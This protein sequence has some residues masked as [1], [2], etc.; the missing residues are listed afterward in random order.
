MSEKTYLILE[1]GSFHEGA[2]FGAPAPLAR[3]Y[4]S[5]EYAVRGTGEVVF[6]TGMTGY[7]EIA[8]D[9][10]YTGQIV[11][12]TY[13][14]IGNYGDEEEWNETFSTSGASAMVVRE[15]YR[16][17]VP[18]G[19]KSLDD[20][21]KERKVPGLSG[22]DT[23]RL[24]LHI[25]DQ[26]NVRACLVRAESSEGLSAEELQ[27][28]LEYLEEY[29]DMEG[30]D[31][32][33]GVAAA[34]P[35][36]SCEPGIPGE[37]AESSFTDGGKLAAGGDADSSAPGYGAEDS[38]LLHFAVIDFGIKANILRELRKR[39]VRVSVI[40][41]SFS[42]EDL[43]ELEVDAVLLANGPGDPAVL[44]SVREKISALISRL[45]L[46]GICLGH[47]L[48]AL[49]LGAETHKMKFGHHG[50]NH[51]VLDLYSG[52]IY[53]TSQNHGFAVSEDSL[54]EG[55]ELWMRNANDGSVEAL[56]HS[57]LP[58]ASVQFHPEAAPG[59]H[60]TLWIFDEF[61]SIARKVAK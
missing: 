27:H 47:Q 53:I 19:R 57:E 37:A 39:G 35:S 24:T 4:V 30:R 36:A 58:I 31:L 38:H 17:P 15:V 28:C 49:A 12:M 33:T 40:P 44:H 16:G 50:L 51:P 61:I 22:V 52:R 60:D 55:V 26:G 14:H 3:D 32:V 56:R 25:R 8:T 29:P 5:G 43:D 54:P 2:G 13:P 46:F 20:F 59:P 1:N 18:Q 45:P 23:R 42:V 21:F 7:H 48:I 6:N 11:V 9:P 10:S 41:H 34:P